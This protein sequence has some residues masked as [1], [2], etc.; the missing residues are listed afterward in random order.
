MAHIP[1]SRYKLKDK[2]KVFRLVEALPF[3]SLSREAVQ[4]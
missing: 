1:Y 3:F 4:N 2:L